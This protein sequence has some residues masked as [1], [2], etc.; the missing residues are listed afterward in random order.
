MSSRVLS[1]RVDVDAVKRRHLL[2]EIVARD[3]ALRRAGS[4]FVGLCPFHAENSPSFHVN[5]AKGVYFCFGCSA[6]GDLID[7]V[8]EM[9]GLDFTGALRWL[10]EAAPVAAAPRPKLS[11]AAERTER[12][13]AVEE[14]RAIWR[15]SKPVAGTPA[16]L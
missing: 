16:E 3:V 9:E 2:S 6:S 12:A 1:P 8:R 15:L 7:Y 11:A 10:G 13:A 4:E 5:D 14:A